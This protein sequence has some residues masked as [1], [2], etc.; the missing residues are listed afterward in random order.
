MNSDEMVQ[1]LY[2]QGYSI[3]YSWDI[4]KDV[5]LTDAKKNWKEFCELAAISTVSP[6]QMPTNMNKKKKIEETIVNKIWTGEEGI[7]ALERC[8]EVKN[9]GIEEYQ[10]LNPGRDY[11]IYID[12]NWDSKR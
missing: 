11:S 8:S 2:K 5:E 6:L 4:V 3:P 9:K 12:E 1:E 10:K 7:E